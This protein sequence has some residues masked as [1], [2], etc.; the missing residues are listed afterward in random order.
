MP[1][2]LVLTRSAR[3]VSNSANVPRSG[4]RP[5]LLLDFAT[6]DTQRTPLDGVGMIADWVLKDNLNVKQTRLFCRSG[7]LAANAKFHF[8]GRVLRPCQLRQR[9]SF[10]A[11][12]EIHKS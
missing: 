5:L 8:L 2:L 9:S 11:P 4:L 12:V 3:W 7:A 1:E 10:M 6:L